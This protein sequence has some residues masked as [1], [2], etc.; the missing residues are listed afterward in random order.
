[1]GGKR[2]KKKKNPNFG[3]KISFFRIKISE[4]NDKK[5]QKIQILGQNPFFFWGGKKSMK[6]RKKIPIF[7]TESTR[8]ITKKTPKKILI[9]RQKNLIFLGKN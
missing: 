4:K 6:N 7:G 3:T 5:T 2:Q 1:M 9:L 8:K